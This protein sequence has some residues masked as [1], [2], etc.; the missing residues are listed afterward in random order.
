V[1]RV[2]AN[3][4]LLRAEEVNQISNLPLTH[5]DMPLPQ[6]P[7]TQ[8][9]E[10]RSAHVVMHRPMM[11]QEGSCSSGAE[12]RRRLELLNWFEVREVAEGSSR[13]PFTRD[14]AQIPRARR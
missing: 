13:I 8:R 1:N 7:K 5:D 6:E 14:P 4:D 12:L 3:W 2:G 9:P 10:A 11:S